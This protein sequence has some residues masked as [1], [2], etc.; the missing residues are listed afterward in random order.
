MTRENATP[1]KEFP[2]EWLSAYLDDELNSQQR[3]V[4]EESL[5]RNA[6][7]AEALK[8]LASTRS[9]LRRYAETTGMSESATIGATS[10]AAASPPAGIPFQL[11][12]SS[13][14]N[15]AWLSDLEDGLESS[16]VS[17]APRIA[18]T[19]RFRQWAVL[20]A[21]LTGVLTVSAALLLWNR[22]GANLQVTLSETAEMASETARMDSNSTSDG[23]AMRASA[24]PRIPSP[25]GRAKATKG[26]IPSA[27]SVERA[28]GAVQE[29]SATATD[30]ISI[31]WHYSPEW[32]ETEMASLKDSH[33]LLRALGSSPASGPSALSAAEHNSKESRDLQPGE[34]ELPVAIL[35][36][37]VSRSLAASRV[38]KGWA[39]TPAWTEPNESLRVLLV[40]SDQLRDFLSV[41][42]ESGEAEVEWL[43]PSQA[44]LESARSILLVH[45]L[46]L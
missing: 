6:Q 17:L 22:E 36:I 9:L 23:V 26:E 37:P 32:S 46:E 2:K 28:A 18:G 12:H 43:D 39:L 21:S 20:A 13:A 42:R 31:V 35:R 25:A 44:A 4:L 1:D 24:A 5:K 38:L 8:D 45:F 27:R 29:E 11:S 19:S 10:P 34:F 14:P 15:K 40:S 30:S 7:L 33:L 3:P 16:S 41:M